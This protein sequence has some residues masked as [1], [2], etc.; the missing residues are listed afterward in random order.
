[1]IPHLL[2]VLPFADHWHDGDGGPH[3]WFIFFP[4]FWGLVALG[5][6]LLVRRSWP[7]RT[8]TGIDL[9][10]RRFAA[11]EIDAEEYARRREVLGG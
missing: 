9:L 6:F 4:L 2:A 11:G 3:W 5:V 7:R 8:D 10:E 1:M